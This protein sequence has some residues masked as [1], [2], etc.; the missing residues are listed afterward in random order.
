[1]LSLARIHAWL[2][3]PAPPDTQAS[4]FPYH[5]SLVDHDTGS[6]VSPQ[7]LYNGRQSTQTLAVDK[8]ESLSV[9]AFTPQPIAP[10][11]TQRYVYV[12]GIDCY[13]QG[14]LFVGYDE[15]KLL[16]LSDDSNPHIFKTSYR[17]FDFHSAAGTTET[18]I[19]ISTARPITELSVFNFPAVL[20]PESPDPENEDSAQRSLSPLNLLLRSTTAGKRSAVD[21]PPDWSV[22]YLT[23]KI[24]P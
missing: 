17:G 5:L 1:M 4:S 23:V 12:M 11:T 20:K 7:T 9:A 19:M 14:D 21:T 22:E 10:L 16:P 8:T 18:F 6:L 15:D 2:T 3:L 24:N 13:G